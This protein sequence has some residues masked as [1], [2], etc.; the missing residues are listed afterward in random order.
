MEKILHYGKVNYFWH[1]AKRLPAAF[2]PFGVSA[3]NFIEIFLL[4]GN[5]LRDTGMLQDSGAK[6]DLLQSAGRSS[7]AAFL[8]DYTADLCQIIAAGAVVAGAEKTVPFRGLPGGGN[9]NL[10]WD[11]EQRWIGTM[12]LFR[13]RNQKN[14]ITHQKTARR[15][16]CGR[17]AYKHC[18]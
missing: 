7:V 13:I 1:G 16:G 5:V 6:A 9:P 11:P 8:L 12:P 14:S 4:V 2:V 17:L 10:C 15:K 18:L 3:V